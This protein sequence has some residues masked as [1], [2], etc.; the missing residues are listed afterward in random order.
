[1]LVLAGTVSHVSVYWCDG[2]LVLASDDGAMI[3]L[4][5]GETDVLGKELIDYTAPPIVTDQINQAVEEAERIAKETADERWRDAI[6]AILADDE[7]LDPD[8]LRASFQQLLDE[9]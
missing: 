8:E 6:G 5:I 7:A 1:M 3:A 2:A 9:S 4:P